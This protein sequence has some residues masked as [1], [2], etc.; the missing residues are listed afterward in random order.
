[1]LD[2]VLVNEPLIKLLVLV[3]DEVVVISGEM[4]VDCELLLEFDVLALSC[5]A[6]M[7][8]IPNCVPEYQ[9]FQLGTTEGLARSDKSNDSADALHSEPNATPASKYFFIPA[10]QCRPV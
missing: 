10:P 6:F 3:P 1:V 7:Q 2:V 9:P 4:T 8:S 5:E